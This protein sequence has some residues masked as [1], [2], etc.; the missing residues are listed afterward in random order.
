MRIHL[1]DELS[2]SFLLLSGY[3]HSVTP[4]LLIMLLPSAGQCLT[5]HTV[6]FWLKIV[7]CHTKVLL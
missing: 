4:R 2:S 6:G 1:K 7:R 3:F 5:D